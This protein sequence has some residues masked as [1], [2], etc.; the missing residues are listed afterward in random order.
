MILGDDFPRAGV[1]AVL[2][3]D[4]DIF[5]DDHRAFFIFCDRFDG[6]D[7]SASCKRAMHATIACPDRRE[8]FEHRRFHGYPI[9]GG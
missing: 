1:N 9:G 5:I 8:P 2:A 3:A 4:A 7:G 6:A